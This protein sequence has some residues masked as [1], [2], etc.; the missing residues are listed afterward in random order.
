MTYLDLLEKTLLYSFWTEPL[1]HESGAIIYGGPT[2]T[3]SQRENGSAAWP[4]YAFTMI[5]Q[6]RLRNIRDLCALVDE[7]NIP[8]GFCECGVWRGGACIY[9]RACLEADRTVWVCDSFA[10]MP[11][12]AA[13]PWWNK[14]HCIR[15]SKEEVESNFNKFELNSNV[16]FIEGDFSNSLSQVEDLSI[17]R[18]DADMYSS[19]V[20]SLRALWPKLSVGGFL[21]VDEYQIV[22]ECRKAVVD[23]FGDSLP[24]FTNIDASGVWCRKT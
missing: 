12:C 22:P 18:L 1:I 9:A 2:V 14:L 10:G 5:G 21:I 13:E 11:L 6:K 20:D 16:R 4:A 7:E 24:T 15:V 8:G 19:T 3:D 17:L 23:Y